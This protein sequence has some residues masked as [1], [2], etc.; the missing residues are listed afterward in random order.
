MRLSAIFIEDH[1]YEEGGYTV[2]LGGI[3]NYNVRLGEGKCLIEGMKNKVFIDSF[4]DSSNTITNLSA[5]VGNNGSGKT[6]LIYEII[7]LLNGNFISGFT[8]WEDEK[9]TYLDGYAWSNVELIVSGFN[10]SQTQAKTDLDTIY[11]SPYLD[12]KKRAA[13]ID[14]SADRYLEE[15]LQNVDSTFEANNRVD[16]SERLK[17]SDYKRFINFQKSRYS[18]KIR[19]SYGLL[20]EEFYRVIFTRHKI[21]ADTNG[22]DFN[23]TP[24]DFRIF[25]NNLYLLI[26]SEYDGFNRN[27]ESDE[28]RYELNKSQFKNFIL[29]DIFCLLIKLMERNNMYLREGHFEDEKSLKMYLKQKPDA[30]SQFKFWLNN[31]YYSKGVK[32]PLPNEEALQILEFLFNYIDD[33]KYS[34][35]FNY[36]DWRSKSLYFEEVNLGTLLDSNQRLLN[37][38]PKYYLKSEE[39]NQFIYRSMGDLQYFAN[40]VYANRNLSSGET[41]MLNLYSKLHDFFSRHV[42]DVQTII[43]KK[44]YVLFLDEADMGYHPSWKKSYI[45]AII[46]FCKAFFNELDAKVQIVI[47]THD[48]LSLSDI[49]NT[50]IVYVIREVEGN[51]QILKTNDFKR[52]SKSFAANVTDL[53]ADSFFLE[54]SLMGD[55]AQA[56]I[57]LTIDWLKPLLEKKR[58][59]PS[60][61]LIVKKEARHYHLNHIKL[62]DEPLLKFKLE[63][64]YQT[65]F[66]EEL[67]KADA[68]RQIEDIANRSGLDVNFDKE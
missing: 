61:V 42:L 9:D 21:N 59:R 23:E 67:D 63:E 13:G 26:R 54:N 31:Y 53:L 52:P 3:L 30:Y 36:L 4:F 41:A 64:M 17:R 40:P 48:A 68:I 49:P 43:R 10:L 34:K 65:I 29:M 55:F 1:D 57:Q 20:D 7:N 51:K 6:T 32:H 12:H 19:D 15:D 16:L 60:T 11:Y 22:I 47:C 58:K 5:L 39:N 24:E 2:N 66:P 33:L 14:I 27:V 35:D 38:L 56:K 18:M 46:D 28:Q 8:I 37:A 25:L 45:T 50:N 44:Y 62:I